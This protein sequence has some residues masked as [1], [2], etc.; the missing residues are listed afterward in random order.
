MSHHYV[1]LSKIFFFNSILLLCFMAGR[2][3][4]QS[5]IESIFGSSNT[6]IMDTTTFGKTPVIVEAESGILGSHLLVQEDG[7]VI[8][9]TTSSNYIGQDH[10]QDSSCVATYDVEF[11]DAGLYN[12]FVRVRVSAGSFDDDSFFYGVGFGEKDV[13]VGADWHLVNGLGSA[14][15]TDPDYY[16]DGPGPVGTEVWKWVNITKNGYQSSPGL[17]FY[18]GED[19]LSRTFQIGSREDGL[20][21]DK[22]AFG[23][24]D[25][26]YTVNDLDT[27]LP[28][29]TTMDD[30]TY[31]YPGPPLAEGQIKFLGCAWSANI[32]NNFASYWN[33]LTPGNMGK[34][35]SVG[36][37]PDTSNWNW[38]SLDYANN[39]AKDNNLIFKNHTLIWG[40]QQPDWINDFSPAEQ[41]I[42]IE[43]WIRRVGERYPDMDMID[44]VNEPL[45][46]HN[47][48]DG[49]VGSANYKDALGGDGETGWDWIIKSFELA[50]K[51]MPDTELI[52]NDFGIINSN[53]NTT[54]YLQI[55]NLL[56]DRGLIDGI[57]VQG[58]RFELENA[59]TTTLKNNLDRLAATGLPIYISEM[60]LGNIGDTGN[61]DDEKQL[62]LYQKIFPV[63]WEHPGIKGI[64]LWGYIEGSTWQE[65]CYLVGYNGEW[66]PAMEWLAQYLEDY[67]TGI[68]E[69]ESALP[70]HYSLEQNF[71]N[72]FNPTTHI[73]YSIANTTKVTLKVF[74]VLGREIQILVN[75]DKSI[76]QYTVTFDG[77]DLP[78]GIYFYNLQAGS[79]S[80]TKKFV[81]MQ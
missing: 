77:K 40:E 79:F 29:S 17:P 6:G 67:S 81:L 42:Y 80:E 27:G 64:T 52:L 53:S 68:I 66:R 33:Q 46:G 72:P 65:T 21:F 55:I 30:S 19:S 41:A 22:I 37:S 50:R 49:V 12:L 59:N 31:V 74:D 5:V 63:L 44:V 15:F 78:S 45:P 34:W 7:D 2:L 9:I 11:E 25:L 54:T 10:P 56:K 24:S 75:E 58:H 73:R 18:V 14:G 39:Y 76:G 51:Y 4:A 57:G 35:E 16:V 32:D 1:R 48:P 23:K 8:Y 28:G 3:F 13:D 70:I 71:P 47:P 36:T 43:T 60:D 69:E 38:S 26:Y 61:P 20:D 62:E